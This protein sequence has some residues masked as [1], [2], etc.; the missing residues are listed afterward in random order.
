MKEKIR[1]WI[2]YV[3]ILIVILLIKTF[4]F[5]TVR[6]HGNSMFETLHNGDIMILD[7][8]SYRFSMVK[9]FDI[10]VI[11]SDG[12]KLIKR[13]IGLPGE[14]VVYKDNVL[15]IDDKKIEDVY[16]NIIEEDF[17]VRLD[18]NEYFVMG[19]NRGDSLDSRMIGPVLENQIL[20]HAT[21]TIFP[22]G[23]F[24]SV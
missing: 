18:E 11:Q 12:S 21:F 19:D 14:T 22:F 9:R 10:V 3:I 5:S 2:P 8:I 17:E 16:N 15:Y 13:V 4:V 6:V 20:G 23:R 24:G 1:E 7:K